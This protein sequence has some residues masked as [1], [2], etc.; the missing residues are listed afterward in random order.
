MPHT[1]RRRHALAAV[2]L[3]LGMLFGLAAPARAV[4]MTYTLTGIM[5]GSLGANNFSNAPFT[6]TQTG[7]T[8]AP[9]IVD[10]F[11]AFA[12]I[13]STIQI[14]ALPAASPSSAFFTL[15]LPPFTPDRVGFVDGSALTGLVFGSVLLNGYD[16]L[17]IG[18][19]NVSFAATFPI[20]TDQG[21]LTMRTVDAVPTELIFTATEATAA[22]P[23]PASLAVLT[24]GL[25]GLG[26]IRRRG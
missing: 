6:W 3:G 5:T 9:T 19:I 7:D 8:S 20:N 15:F 26:L 10:G 4:I 18:P 21:L 16:L 1:P 25:L 17:A 11:P 2:L 23:E 12:A 13:T 24:A 14:G 22:I